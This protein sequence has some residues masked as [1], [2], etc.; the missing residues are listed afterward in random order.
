M[1]YA[2]YGKSSGRHGAPS[3]PDRREA[4]RPA[5]TKGV[6]L[7]L[8]RWKRFAGTH[9]AKWAAFVVRRS[10]AQGRF[11]RPSEIPASRGSAYRFSQT[12]SSLSNNA[13]V[14]PFSP[15]DRRGLRW[16]V[17][18]RGEC[19]KPFVPGP[20]LVAVARL[21]WHCIDLHNNVRFAAAVDSG[22]LNIWRAPNG[23]RCTRS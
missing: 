18:R 3:G 12:V 16:I 8:C 11:D 1:R 10:N 20:V 5:R 22:D 17:P 9:Q 13:G 14:D 21:I 23:I 15:R 4:W 6:D 2:G 7:R 19:C